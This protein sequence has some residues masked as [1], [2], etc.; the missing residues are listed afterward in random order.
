M[1]ETGSMSDGPPGP[2]GVVWSVKTDHDADWESHASY[3]GIPRR[4]PM[5]AAISRSVFRFKYQLDRS[6]GGGDA[7]TLCPPDPPASEN[8]RIAAPK[9]SFP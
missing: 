9:S 7:K 2:L 6:K 4:T 1:M 5:P 3:I 8:D